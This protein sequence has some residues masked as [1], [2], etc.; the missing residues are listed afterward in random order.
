MYSF[1]LL[2]DRPLEG[3]LHLELYLSYH[4]SCTWCVP[5]VEIFLINHSSPTTTTVEIFK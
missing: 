4:Y 5:L 2:G 1:Q 3:L